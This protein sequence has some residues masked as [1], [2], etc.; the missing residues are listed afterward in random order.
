MI[1]NDFSSCVYLRFLRL[2]VLPILMI[3]KEIL[4]LCLINNDAAKV[5]HFFKLEIF[6][7]TER[8][9]FVILHSGLAALRGAP[10]GKQV[11]VLR[12]PAAVSSKQLATPN[13]M[14][15]RRVKAPWEGWRE[16]RNKPE[17]LP[18]PEKK[19]SIIALE[20]RTG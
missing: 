9:F 14:P 5:Q 15:L 3:F 2:S 19:R 7:F 13:G 11:Q 12:S 8:F 18:N 20:E 1:T 10:R 17:D 4:F 6:F 16:A